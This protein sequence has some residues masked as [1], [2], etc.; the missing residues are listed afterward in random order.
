MI[1]LR[2]QFQNKNVKKYDEKNICLICLDEEA[3]CILI[4]C[5]HLAF[6]QNCKHDF[7]K[8]MFNCPLCR[9]NY[10]EILTV[11]NA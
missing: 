7:E 6:C 5:L 2:R 1:T 10:S 3:T 9:L 8:Y 11:E 4:P